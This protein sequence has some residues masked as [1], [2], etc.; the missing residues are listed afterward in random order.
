MCCCRL[1]AGSAAGTTTAALGCLPGALAV[2]GG[3]GIS[4]P[5][6]GLGAL[7]AARV[8]TR[9]VYTLPCYFS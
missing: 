2:A 4:A 5:G 7:F 9:G 1:A 3:L 6:S 8:G